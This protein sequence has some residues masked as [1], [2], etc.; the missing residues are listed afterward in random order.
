[1]LR[2]TSETLESNL[3]TPTVSFMEGT[4]S[5]LERTG[6][7]VLPLSIG[8]AVSASPVAALMKLDIEISKIYYNFWTKL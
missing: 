5:T 4:P 2:P 6:V 8:H 7:I 3:P 1:L